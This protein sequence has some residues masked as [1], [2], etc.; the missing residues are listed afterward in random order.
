MGLNKSF[1][2]TNEFCQLQKL[3][4]KT[5]LYKKLGNWVIFMK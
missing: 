2:Q 3:T 5:C 1:L 4:K